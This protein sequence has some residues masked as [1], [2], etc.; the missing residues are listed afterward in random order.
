MQFYLRGVIGD[1]CLLQTFMVCFVFYVN[2]RN[3]ATGIR[4]RLVVVNISKKLEISQP[5]NLFLYDFPIQLLELKQ[6]AVILEEML[7][8]SLEICRKILFL[9][10]CN[11]LV[12]Y[13]SMRFYLQI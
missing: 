13:S 7:K 12:I 11:K 2:E 3:A 8:N 1:V 6:I 5:P 10:N 9:Q 4:T